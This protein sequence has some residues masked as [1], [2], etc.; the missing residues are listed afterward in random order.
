MLDMSNVYEAIEKHKILTLL[1]QSLVEITYWD[2]TEQRITAKLTLKGDTPSPDI[3]NLPQMM[4]EHD[5]VFKLRAW[6]PDSSSW[7]SL[8][9]RKVLSY[10]VVREE[11]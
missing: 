5:I 3:L 6:C 8:D 4:D 1:K 9:T 11:N 2:E 7:H 10:I